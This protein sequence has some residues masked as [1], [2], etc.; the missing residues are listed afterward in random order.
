LACSLKR[1]ELCE[2]IDDPVQTAG[3]RSDVAS[4]LLVA[5]RTEDALVLFEK[6]YEAVKGTDHAYEAAIL[7]NLGRSHG[8][9]G[10]ARRAMECYR[11]CLE[12]Q[13]RRGDR[14]GTAN[15]RR[16]LA[17]LMMAQRQHRAALE[18]AHDGLEDAIAAG[19]QRAEILLRHLLSRH[20]EARGENRE[21][22][23][24]VRAGIALVSHQARGLSETEAARYRERR[25][26]LYSTGIL[27]GRSLG[28]METVYEMAEARR[29][30]TLI[31]SLRATDEL[32]HDLL[33]ELLLREEAGAKREEQRSTARLKT[34]IDAGD[35]KESRARRKEVEAARERV[36]EVDAR[37]QRAAKSGADLAPPPIPTSE[38]VR[39][40]L[41]PDEALVLY[42]FAFQRSLAV[43]LTPTETRLVQLEKRPRV[44]TAIRR[45]A[46]AGSDPG[47]HAAAIRRLVLDPLGLE[48]KT[49]RLIVSPTLEYGYLPFALLAEGR[50]V[51]L[52]PSATAFAML[53]RKAAET[54]SGK[55]V[56]AL[57]DPAYARRGAASPD[58]DVPA[59][60]RSGWDLVPLPNSREEAEKVAEVALLGKAATEEGLAA[61]LKDRPRWRAVH[62][63]GHG[64]ID[65]ERPL[66][67]AIAL[68]P[69]PDSD[70]FLRSMEILR[71]KVPADLVV[72]SACETAR[73]KV[74]RS[75]GIVGLTRAF[76]IAGAPRV[77]CSLWKVDD[78]ATKA[79]MVKFYELWNPTSGDGLPAAEALRRAQEFVRGHK[80]WAHP[81][82]WA[83]WVLWG[84]PE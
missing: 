81:R 43:V 38:E 13:T 25:E 21:A 7:A 57:A 73:G 16:H 49:K 64:L 41:R 55:G 27:A 2:G 28:E 4:R 48:G 61:A 56:L 80:R 8:A 40:L 29:A 44:Q 84:L 34:A 77:L 32:V 46:G 20:F 3:A 78:E 19:E 35:L 82:F 53:R 67:S 26:E 23:E 5:G 18:M 83:A 74:F 52:V 42:S 76:M 54:A 22:L 69:G 15:A 31:E 68:T 10:R 17:G 36:A 12:I 72:L 58:A 60:L 37:I 6:A 50:D 65:T 45:M 63:A 14:A 66:L 39:K 33:P 24:H 75:E 1:M 71:M 59:A 51:V 11:G 62:L 47:G 9:L 79:L 30:G 70:G